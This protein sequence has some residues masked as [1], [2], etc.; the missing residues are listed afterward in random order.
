M[1]DVPPERQQSRDVAE[2]DALD[3]AATEELMGEKLAM[4]RKL[5]PFPN[6]Y[7]AEGEEPL[8][9]GGD[10]SAGRL[11]AAYSQGIFPWY[12][13]DVPILWWSPD[14]RFVLYPEEL[15]V[16][17]KLRQVMRRGDWVVTFDTAFDEVIR[18][19]AETPRPDQDGTWLTADMIHA[20]EVLHGL[21]FAHSAEC[22]LDGTV[23]GGLYGVALGSVFFGESMFYSVEDASKV[24]LVRLMEALRDWGFTLI[25][26]QQE[27]DHMARFGAR[28]V[29]RALFLDLLAGALA[30]PTRHGSWRVGRD[31]LDDTARGEP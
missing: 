5:F 2:R 13:E 17:R 24:A 9:W 14:P 6:P 28:S 1:R 27:T 11:L 23:V 29:P 3:G 4:L 19:C 20:Y 18:G 21:G 8:A 31:T 12:D 22:R 16:P 7:E 10:L 26:C 15:K 30:A 25:D